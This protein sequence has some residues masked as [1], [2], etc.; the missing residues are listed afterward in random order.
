MYAETNT[1]DA[2]VQVRG[3]AAASV[4]PAVVEV[5][6]PAASGPPVVEV[7]RSVDPGSTAGSPQ[8]AT[9]STPTARAPLPTVQMNR[10]R[11]ITRLW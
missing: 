7:T 11:S 9:P 3:P 8:A 4:S 2:L 1:K 10:R 6:E 5:A